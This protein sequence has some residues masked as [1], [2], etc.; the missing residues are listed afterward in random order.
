MLLEGWI[1]FLIWT[2]GII[3]KGQVAKFQTT[4][5]FITW[6]LIYIA[7]ATDFEQNLWKINYNKDFQIYFGKD[8]FCPIVFCR[9]SPLAPWIKE[10][11]LSF[12]FGFAQNLLEGPEATYTS[13]WVGLEVGQ[14]VSGLPVL[15]QGRRNWGSGEAIVP[16]FGQEQ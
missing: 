10:K 5:A 8:P 11:K 4:L 15:D 9:S 2:H 6:I 3:L 13:E 14:K 7:S 1:F 16:R 12:F